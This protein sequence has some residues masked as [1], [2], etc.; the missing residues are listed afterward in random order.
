MLVTFD[1]LARILRLTP[2]CLEEYK[3]FI[4][5]LKNYFYAQY[6]RLNLRLKNL[7][8]IQLCNYFFNTCF[9]P[10]VIEVILG[11]SNKFLSFLSQWC[12]FHQANMLQY[13]LLIL[14][15]VYQLIF[16]SLFTIT[17]HEDIKLREIQLI[18]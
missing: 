11:K 17:L 16:T 10:E 4:K 2:R 14:N 6:S 18:N 1:L 5:F 13:H 15:T 3:T 7:L 12:Y 9:F 8:Q